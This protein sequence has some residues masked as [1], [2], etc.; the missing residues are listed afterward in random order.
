MKLKKRIGNKILYLYIIVTFIIA[1]MI[2]YTSISKAQA[3]LHLV[4]ISGIITLSF[5]ILSILK[6]KTPRK[7]EGPS[8]SY[9]YLSRNGGDLRRSHYKERENFGTKIIEKAYGSD[10]PRL[11]AD[12]NNLGL[13]LQVLGNLQEARKCYERAIKIDEKVFGP[14]HPLVAKD[15]NNLGSVLQ[16]LGDLQEARKCYERAL[17]IFRAKLGEDHPRTRLVATNLKAIS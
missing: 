14:D 8:I 3:P 10:N 17:K 6:Y 15:L 12:L 7:I 4:T 11:A 1:V 5:I 13:V 16:D 9:E 2:Y